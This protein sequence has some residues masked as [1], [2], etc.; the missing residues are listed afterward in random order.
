MSFISIFSAPKHLTDPPIATIQ[1]NAINSWT[2]LPDVD[3][4]LLGDEAGLAQAAQELGVKH[5]ADVD[6]SPS[7][8]PLLSAMFQVARKST[9][10]PLLC[11]VNAD[12]LLGPDFVDAAR[13]V[14]AQREKFV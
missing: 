8:A 10:S 11:A 4:L 9:D 6:R 14:S 5:I 7:G 12:I 13:C 2:R 3:V 1:R